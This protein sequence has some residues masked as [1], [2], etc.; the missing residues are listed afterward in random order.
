MVGRVAH[1]YQLGQ[2]RPEAGGGASAQQP[3]FPSLRQGVAGVAHKDETG[4]IATL[5]CRYAENIGGDSGK[6]AEILNGIFKKSGSHRL[7]IFLESGP[8]HSPQRETERVGDI[9]INH[10]KMMKIF[11]KS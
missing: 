9:K 10:N 4:A 8:Q 3:L 11:N 5:L 2:G 7:A 1:A 6:R